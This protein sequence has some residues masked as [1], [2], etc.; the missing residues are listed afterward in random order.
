MPAG[1]WPF[2]TLY[3][4]QVYSYHLS[5]G[6]LMASPTAIEAIGAISCIYEISNFFGINTFL[7][8][9]AILDSTPIFF[10]QNSGKVFYESSAAAKYYLIYVFME[11]SALVVI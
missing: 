6:L 2:L 7:K 9:S 4:Q 5:P 8:G 3:R 1:P 11:R 10:R